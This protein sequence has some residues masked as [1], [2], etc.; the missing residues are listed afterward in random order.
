MCPVH[1]THVARKSVP[2][3]VPHN[4]GDENGC[5]IAAAVEVVART[6]YVEAVKVFDLGPRT[7]TI[8]G[9]PGDRIG[10]NL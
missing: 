3:C 9:G 1:T 6:G 4:N 7:G 2:H 8:R 10:E 5:E